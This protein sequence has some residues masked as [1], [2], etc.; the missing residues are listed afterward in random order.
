MIRFLALL[1]LSIATACGAADPRVRLTSEWPLRVGNYKTVTQEWTRS[2]V[3]RGS[4]QEVMELSALLKSPEWH[5]AHAEKDANNRGLVGEARA[6]R[7]AQAQAEAAGPF[8]F[9]LMVTTWDRRENDLDRGKRSV[10]R[11]ALLGSDGH[12]ILPLE[13]VKDKRPAFVVRSEFPALGD[14][15]QT[16]HVRFPREANVLGPDV[17]QV[18]LRISGERGGLEVKWDAP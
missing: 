5:A 2:A 9:V 6:Q 4:Y 1:V 8:E 16:Y 15:A 14:F 7:I 12:E 17:K 11:V 10:W 3:L 18:R 13:I